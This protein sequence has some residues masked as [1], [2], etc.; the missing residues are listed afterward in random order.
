MP[1]RTGAARRGRAAGGGAV[2][3]AALACRHV[4]PA[5]TPPRIEPVRSALLGARARV[6][7]QSDPASLL[8]LLLLLH[9]RVHERG[10][11]R[12]HCLCSW[13]RRVVVAR[14][15]SA[16]FC[17]GDPSPSSAA[18]MGFAEK[19]SSV[20]GGG[21]RCHRRSCSFHFLLERSKSLEN[22]DRGPIWT[23]CY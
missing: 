3:E 10:S 23:N 6:A 15:Y 7:V 18:V 1:C 2:H 12:G 21:F 16:L 4:A 9:L 5:P 17:R 13:P 22:T 11:S 19:G 20:T 8:L 14:R